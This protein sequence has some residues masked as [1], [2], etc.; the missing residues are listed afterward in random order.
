MRDPLYLFARHLTWRREGNLGA[1]EDLLAGLDDSRSDVRLLAENL[2]HGPCPRPDPNL[3]TR[4]TDSLVRVES[5][6]SRDSEI[7]PAIS[8]FDGS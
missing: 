1:Y 2:L 4:N 3:K 5:G 6:G 8:R 7:R